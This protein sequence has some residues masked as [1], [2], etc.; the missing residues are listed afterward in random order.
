MI[1]EA[2]IAVLQ[3]VNIIPGVVLKINILHVLY[4][5]Q[6]ATLFLCCTLDQKR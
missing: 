3:T 5:L 1:Y 6:I 2:Q 4:Y